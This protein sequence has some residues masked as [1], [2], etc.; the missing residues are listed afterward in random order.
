MVRLVVFFPV[1]NGPG[2]GFLAPQTVLLR[3][4]P[5]L[6]CFEIV[7]PVFGPPGVSL[8]VTHL[9]DRGCSGVIFIGYGAV[10]AKRL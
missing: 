5:A 6:A 4:V 3:A 7:I 9:L 8:V 2:P 1:L 10:P